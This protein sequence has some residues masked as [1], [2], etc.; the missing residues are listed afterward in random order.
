LRIA[1]KVKIVTNVNDEEINA[2]IRNDSDIPNPI[3]SA[4]NSKPEIKP[5]REKALERS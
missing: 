5:T 4:K 1:L 3:N 2:R